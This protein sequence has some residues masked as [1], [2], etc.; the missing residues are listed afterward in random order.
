MWITSIKFSF[1]ITNIIGSL[2]LVTKEQL[3]IINISFFIDMLTS[4]NTGYYDNGILI[5]ER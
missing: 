2:D 3:I 4:L 1:F 5:L